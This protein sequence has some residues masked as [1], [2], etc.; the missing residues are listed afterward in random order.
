MSDSLN[1]FWGCIVMLIFITIIIYNLVVPRFTM[2]EYIRMLLGILLSFCVL[3]FI[4]KDIAQIS[5][6]ILPIIFIYLKTRKILKCFFIQ[7]LAF[8]IYLGI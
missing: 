1:L 7:A 3:F 5:F 8:I 2:K 6:Y 4:N